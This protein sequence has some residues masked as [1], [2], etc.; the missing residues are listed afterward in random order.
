MAKDVVFSEFEVD[1]ISF[2]FSEGEAEALSCIGKFEEEMEVKTVTKKCRG[3]VIKTRTRGTGNG[4]IKTSMH[5]PK[6]TY[7]KLF[8]ME[9]DSFIAGAYAFGENSLLPE[10]LMAVHVTDEDGK[11]KLKAY[12]RVTATTGPARSVE[13][14]GDEVE[15]IEPEFSVMPDDDGEGLYELFIDDIDDSKKADIIDKWMTSF[16]PDLILKAKQQSAD[17]AGSEAANVSISEEGE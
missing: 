6:G 9:R 2:K 3:K 11:E 14:G 8:A 7:A 10:C 12:P 4:T 16:T 15:E 13:N 1:K 17:E 5:V